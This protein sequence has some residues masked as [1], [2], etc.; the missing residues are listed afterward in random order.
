MSAWEEEY[1]EPP[2]IDEGWAEGYHQI[3]NGEIIKLSLMEDRHILNTIAYFGRRGDYD[4]TPLE[5]EL[6]RREI[7]RNNN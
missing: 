5:D 4:T 2:R 7:I 3:N 1:H 6:K